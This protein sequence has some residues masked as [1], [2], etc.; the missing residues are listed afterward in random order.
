MVRA[1]ESNM[2]SKE[3]DTSKIHWGKFTLMAR[4]ILML[5][6]LQDKIRSSGTYG[7]VERK[8]IRE[9]LNNDVMDIEVRRS[10][11]YQNQALTPIPTDN[12]FP[13]FPTA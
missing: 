2:D 10:L 7:F 9:L 1:N 6:G 13:C 8:W 4:M 12:T 5:Q 11:M 3:E